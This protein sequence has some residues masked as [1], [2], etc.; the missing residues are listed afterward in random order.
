MAIT[1]SPLTLGALVAGTAMTPITL[2]AAGGTAPY[3][4]S[5]D[6]ILPRGLALNSTTGVISGTPV[7]PGDYG[8]TV[9]VMDATEATFTIVV[10]G[11]I[12]GTPNVVGSP[13]FNNINSAAGNLTTVTVKTGQ[14]LTQS[15][16]GL[17]FTYVGGDT[18]SVNT[19]EVQYLRRDGIIV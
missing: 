9:V 16:N 6:G 15:I 4:Y 18:V 8:F 3:V 2:A 10:Q 13:F 12:G 1:L 11:G 7:T 14:R 5:I 17:D 19:F